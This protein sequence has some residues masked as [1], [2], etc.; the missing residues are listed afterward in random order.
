MGFA[1]GTHARLTKFIEMKEWSYYD[2][3]RKKLILR[4]GKEDVIKIAKSLTGIDYL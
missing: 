3:K 4:T 1:V 2:S